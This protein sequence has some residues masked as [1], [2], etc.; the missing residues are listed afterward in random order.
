MENAGIVPL[1]QEYFVSIIATGKSQNMHQNEII[2]S[3]ARELRTPVAVMKSNIQLLKK[4]CTG[5]EHCFVEESF[6]LC[7]DSV[8]NI[9][10]FINCVSFLSDTDQDKPI[11]KKLSFDLSSFF[12]QVMG[13]LRQ[14]NLD[15]SR[16][17]VHIDVP[18]IHIIADKYL[19]NRILIN[20]L[21]NALKFSGSIVEVFVSATNNQLTVRVRDYG[22][23]IPEEEIREVFNPFVRARNV[24]MI[25]GTGLGLSIVSKAVEC[26]EGAVY[27]SS[28]VGK[29]T[30]FKVIIPLEPVLKI[31]SKVKKSNHPILQF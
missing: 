3:I 28:I 25:S 30:E 21:V 16:I 13:E 7:E 5:N 18:G 9:L 15:V 1:N 31:N 12:H 23:G 27:V 20:L 6:S 22:I 14:S 8:D 17:N 2:N 26:L 29:G 11:L 10:Q 24:K 4:N 19:L